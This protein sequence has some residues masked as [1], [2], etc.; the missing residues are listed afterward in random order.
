MSYTGAA[1]LGLAGTVLLDLVVLRTF[2]L[3]RKA[4]WAAYGITVFFQLLLNGVLTCR[5]V[6]QYAESAITGWRVACAPVEDLAFGFALVTQTLCWWV[7]WG[8]RLRGRG[9]P[10][11]APGRRP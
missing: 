3:R 1:A 6:V 2:L 8:Q 4:F 9:A 5:G 7:W 11:V 10:G